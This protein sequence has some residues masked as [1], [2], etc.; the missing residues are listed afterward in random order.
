MDYLPIQASTVS[1]ECILSS[2]T[3]TATVQHDH[4]S[5]AFL[6]ALQILKYDYRKQRLTFS[7]GIVLDQR[8]LADDESDELRG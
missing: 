8:D 5:A 7:E 1:A 2:R 4:D 3:E 6:E